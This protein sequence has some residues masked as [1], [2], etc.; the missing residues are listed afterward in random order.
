MI[1]DTE[2]LWRSYNSDIYGLQI[3]VKRFLSDICINLDDISDLPI[4]YG[5]LD[6]IKDEQK[7]FVRRLGESQER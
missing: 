1:S 6:I 2:P 7:Q 4:D 3:G 5:Q